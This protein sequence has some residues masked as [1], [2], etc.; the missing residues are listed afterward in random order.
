VG[1]LALHP[2]GSRSH[3]YV[4]SASAATRLPR[5][6]WP[7]RLAGWPCDL[8][9]CGFFLLCVR[10]RR[11]VAV[12]DPYELLGVPRDASDERIKVAYELAINRAT[13]DGAIRYAAELSAA[14]DTISSA[15]RRA[16]YE[17]HGFTAIRERS[18]GSAAPPRDWRVM[19][20]P[21]PGSNGGSRRGVKAAVLFL[22]AIGLTAWFIGATQHPSRSRPPGLTTPVITNPVVVQPPPEHQVLCQ[23]TARGRGYVYSEPVTNTPRCNN[24]AVPEVLGHN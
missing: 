8:S 16:L 21:E 6:S 5:A 7:Q 10:Y 3:A 12:K 14:Y 20:Q 4:T 15:R 2:T 13:R 9:N 18:P 24:G 23:T 1:A 11:A 19:Q 17:R 22:F